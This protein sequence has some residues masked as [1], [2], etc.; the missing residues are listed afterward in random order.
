MERSCSRPVATLIKPKDF[1]YT[2]RHVFGVQLAHLVYMQDAGAP[3]HSSILDLRSGHTGFLV[4]FGYFGNRHFFLNLQL[5]DLESTART[6]NDTLLEA[7]RVNSQIVLT[8]GR[9][10]VPWWNNK[11]EAKRKLVRVLWNRE[12]LK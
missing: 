11:L 3:L 9:K 4:R 8:K 10:D 5:L 2:S 1:Q 12:K 7:Y 6:I